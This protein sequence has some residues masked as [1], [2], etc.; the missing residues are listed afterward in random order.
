M[1]WYSNE[2][3]AV[4]GRL[5]CQ[6]IY[7]QPV[8]TLVLYMLG[9]VEMS[10]ISDGTAKTLLYLTFQITDRTESLNRSIKKR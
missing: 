6:E 10:S 1:D 2:Q 9:V 7:F 4:A 8:K 5:Q 3:N